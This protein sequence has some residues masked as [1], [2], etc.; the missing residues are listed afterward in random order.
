MITL[1]QFGGTEQVPPSLI[2]NANKTIAILNE[3]FAAIPQ[4][5]FRFTSGYRSPAHN[6]AVGGVPN[7]YH[8]TA[9]AG[10]FVPMVGKAKDYEAQV[11]AIAAKYNYEVLYHNVLSGLHFHIEPK[12]HKK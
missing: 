10:D 8:L 3:I 2:P 11:I 7:S 6:K 12:P 5:M 1:Q 4:A 9:L